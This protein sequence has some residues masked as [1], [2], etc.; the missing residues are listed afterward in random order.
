MSNKES[1]YYLNN[2]IRRISLSNETD[3]K[4]FY[5]KNFLRFY[6]LKKYLNTSR[7]EIYLAMLPITIVMILLLKRYCNAPVIVSERGDPSKTVGKSKIN[8]YIMR[9]LY[10]K[11]DG[12]V[13]QTRDA[14]SFYEEILPVNGVIIPNAVNLDFVNQQPSIERNK[15]IVS[16]GRLTEQKNFPVLINSFSN[17]V[18]KFPEYQLIIYG[19]GQLRNS[20]NDQIIKLNLK[21]KVLLPGHVN[22]IKEH[23]NNA[24]MFVLSSNYEGM[25]NALME[26]M[27][28]GIPVI[29][30]DCPVGG[31][32]NLINSGENGILIP[33]NNRF[34]MEKAM[35]KI[36]SDKEFAE[37]IGINA[38]N[39]TKKYSPDRIYQEWETYLMTYL[40][41]K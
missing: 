34:E 28:L 32:R 13:F 1:S 6:R 22:N 41:R 39:I 38:L 8:K 18:K 31:P 20:L 19:E 21:N 3:S 4:N 33:I 24:S 26:A 36:I 15:T 12:F 5:R 16:I 25:P 35:E 10:K 23:I 7:S 14:M 40:T 37:K 17:I 27:A 29:A 30:T 11:A 9:Q 2:N